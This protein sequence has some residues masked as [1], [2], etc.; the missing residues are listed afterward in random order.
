MSLVDLLDG[1]PSNA[2]TFTFHDVIDASSYYPGDV[3]HIDDDATT[4]RGRL[5]RFAIDLPGMGTCHFTSVE[6]THLDTATHVGETYGSLVMILETPT[7]TPLVM[8]S[9][10]CGHVYPDTVRGKPAS[11]FS[12]W[13]FSLG[14]GALGHVDGDY[15]GY[16]LPNDPL[17]PCSGELRMEI[18]LHVVSHHRVTSSPPP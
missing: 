10:T 13:F 12:G 9:E 17:H 3:V 1:V 11:A 18:R 8:T 14:S 16:F 4:V 6:D 15:H 7:H 5:S 2:M